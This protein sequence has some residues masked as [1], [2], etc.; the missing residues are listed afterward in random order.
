MNSISPDD[1]GLYW[2]GYVEVPIRPDM[3][4]PN[5]GLQPPYGNN[6][7]QPQGMPMEGVEVPSPG[8]P[9]EAVPAPTPA[10]G[11]APGPSARGPVRPNRPNTTVVVSDAPPARRATPISSRRGMPPQTA[12]PRQ[13][14]YN[15]SNPQVRKTGGQANAKSSPPGF[16]GPIGYDVK[17]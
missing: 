8:P 6:V 13:P 1:C 17:N 15:P 14:S 7:P 2:K 16:I 10:P 3:V 11:P 5:N 12:A 4:Y 9:A